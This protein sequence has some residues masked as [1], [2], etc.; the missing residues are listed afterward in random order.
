VAAGRATE[1]EADADCAFDRTTVIVVSPSVV[2]IIC[3]TELIVAEAAEVTGPREAASASEVAENPAVTASICALVN[4]CPAE[5]TPAMNGRAA[6]PKSNFFMEPLLGGRIDP[7]LIP[8]PIVALEEP[9]GLEGCRYMQL[10]ED[11]IL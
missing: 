11:R 7:R 1:V 10:H 2:F 9:R 6:R 5:A 3:W 4:N 8:G